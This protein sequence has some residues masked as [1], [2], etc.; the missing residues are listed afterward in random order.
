MK[1]ENFLK[2]L[3]AGAFSGN[4]LIVECF[5]RKIL[6]VKHRIR[7][8]MNPVAENHQ[9][10]AVVE[11]L[12]EHDVA[13]SENEEVDMPAVVIVLGKFFKTLLSLAEILRE[14]VLRAASARPTKGKRDSPARM[15]SSVELLT[16]FVA[17]H[18]PQDAER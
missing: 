1:C 5:E 7:A 8:E 15:D 2:P 11:S 10:A 17:E 18:R 14:R 12:V 3:V 6:A 4:L 13:G 9:L 16:H